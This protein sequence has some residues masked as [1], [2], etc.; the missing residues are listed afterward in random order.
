MTIQTIKGHTY[1]L[2]AANA[3]GATYTRHQGSGAWGP[4]GTI[5]FTNGSFTY[6]TTSGAD[7]ILCNDKI[8]AFDFWA[9]LGEMFRLYKAAFNRVP[10]EAGLSNNLALLDGGLTMN[11]MAAAFLVST[12]GQSVYPPASTD[13]A[14]VTLLYLHVL[15]RVPA[16]AEVQAW[17]D[18]RPTYANNAAWRAGALIGFSDSPEN[19]ANVDGSLL[20]GVVLTRSY[21]GV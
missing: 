21:F 13:S 18:L 1:E 7:R 11:Q 17:L 4:A 15:A 5:E 19:H 20:G 12:E 2:V 3:I 8:V 9:N 6:N 14:Y 10:D 16:Q